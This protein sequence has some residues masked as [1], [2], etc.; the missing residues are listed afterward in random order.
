MARAARHSSGR[1]DWEDIDI[2]RSAFGPFAAD[3]RYLYDGDL[4]KSINVLG[5]VPAPVTIRFNKPQ[6]IG[7][8]QVVTTDP[9]RFD[10]ALGAAI[11][12]IA[13]DGGVVPPGVGTNLFPAQADRAHIAPPAWPTPMVGVTIQMGPGLG[14]PSDVS[15]FLMDIG[16]GAGAPTPATPT[17]TQLVQQVINDEAV[18]TTVGAGWVGLPTS[19]LDKNLATGMAN[20]GP[21]SIVITLNF[22]ILIGRVVLSGVITNGTVTVTDSTGIA[23]VLGAAIL[24]PTGWD[25]DNFTPIMAAV[26]RIDEATGP[27]SITEASILKVIE[28]KGAVSIDWENTPE[29]PM[30]VDAQQ[31]VTTEE[32]DLVNSTVTGFHVIGTLSGLFDHD[33]ATGITADGPVP[34]VVTIELRTIMLLSRVALV[35]MTAQTGVYFPKIEVRNVM[36]TWVTVLDYANDLNWYD[37]VDSGNF[38][39]DAYAK[40]PSRGNAGPQSPIEATAVRITSNPLAQMTTTI[41]EVVIHKTTETKSYIYNEPREPAHVQTVQQICLDEVDTQRTTFSVTLDGFFDTIAIEKLFNKQMGVG[42]IL[43]TN[44]IL[45]GTGT[46]K[47]VFRFP[48]LIARIA[49]IGVFPAGTTIGIYTVGS[50][51]PVGIYGLAVSNTHGFDS[52]NFVPRLVTAIEILLPDDAEIDEITIMKVIEMKGTVSFDVAN[53]PQNPVYTQMPQVLS[54]GEIDATLTSWA[55]AGVLGAWQDLFDWDQTTGVQDPGGVGVL[56]VTFKSPMLISRVAALRLSP[57]GAGFNRPKIEVQRMDGTWTTVLD[58]SDPI[59]YTEYQGIDTGNFKAN[60]ALGPG[61]AHQ[62]TSPIMARGVRLSNLSGIAMSISEV[63]ILKT[64]ETKAFVY[65]EPAEPVFVQDER[66]MA[67]DEIDLHATT[68]ASADGIWS[69]YAVERLFNKQVGVGQ[70]GFTYVSTPGVLTVAFR[71]PTLINRIGLVGAYPTGTA[72]QVTSIDGMVTT[73][74]TLAAPVSLGME[75]GNFE[76]ILARNIIITMSGNATFDEIAILKAVEEKAFAEMVAAELKEFY[77][78]R[79]YFDPLIANQVNYY[80]LLLRRALE[81]DAD[82]DP[83]GS[84]DQTTVTMTSDIVDSSRIK[85]Q[86]HVPTDDLRAVRHHL[87]ALATVDLGSNARLTTVRYCLYRR[88]V[89]AGTLTALTAVKSVAVNADGATSRTVRAVLQDLGFQ[90][91]PEHEVLVLEVDVWGRQVG[92]SATPAP[93][94]LIHNRGLGDCKLDVEA[95]TQVAA[96][97]V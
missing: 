91:I 17:H 40:G 38:K 29:D 26:I 15:E 52:D 3:P 23:H 34:L 37:G 32:I 36:G 20:A 61:R 81:T 48:I 8:C 18:V 72:V 63:R 60:A 74:L 92:S 24:A 71:H 85:V 56:T 58:Y 96:R 83:T 27:I 10:T 68:F 42:G 79:V 6:F 21:G 47:I 53:E 39:A 73:V 16:A 93:I 95:V 77:G 86:F 28:V 25:S 35:K 76:P 75:T 11:T 80:Y 22:P 62:P 78:Q 88:N 97:S 46:I 45:V 57:G 84:L 67:T 70:I 59:D 31:I 64:I 54:L 82:N 41:G 69:S 9:S 2:A 51:L 7:H 14:A 1:V 90:R 30:H 44:G 5:G 87:T 4:E 65:N 33:R 94:S 43:F 49:G 50:A 19:I 66:Q 13:A 55:G 12:W 89:T